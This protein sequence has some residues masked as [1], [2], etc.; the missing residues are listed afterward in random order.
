MTE[1]FLRGLPS[2]FDF[3]ISLHD[4]NHK[5]SKCF[6]DLQMLMLKLTEA[7]MHHFELREEFKEQLGQEIEKIRGELVT[8]CEQHFYYFQVG[9]EKGVREVARTVPFEAP[10]EPK[11]SRVKSSIRRY[12]DKVTNK[13][14]VSK[15]LL[16]K[17]VVKERLSTAD[18]LIRN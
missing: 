2:L 7:V 1:E 16:P 4:V 10:K 12:Q 17:N 3:S 14:G 9:L 5:V 11:M 8:F 18:P 6:D 13:L 15:W